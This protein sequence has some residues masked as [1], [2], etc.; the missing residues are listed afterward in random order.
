MDQLSE[1]L[2]RQIT[3]KQGEDELLVADPSHAAPNTNDHSLSLVG[4]VVI[5][6]ELSINSIRANVRRLLNPVK[7]VDIKGLGPNMVVMHFA[8]PLD[9]KHA[10]GGCPWAIDRHALLLE[11]LDPAIKPEH[12]KLTHMPI[13]IRVLQLSLSNRSESTARL[14]GNSLGTFLEIPKSTPNHY[15]PYFRLKIAV[16]VSKPLKRGVYFQG[17]EGTKQWIQIL[18]ERLPTFCFLCG[19][20]GHGEA[21]CPTRYEEGFEE[22]EGDL[23]YG[24]WMRA[25]TESQGDRGIG[26]LSIRVTPVEGSLTRDSQTVRR[27]MEVFSVN[28]H[29]RKYQS[30][31]DSA[32]DENA[33]PNIHS[34]AKSVN[35]VSSSLPG[36]RKKILVPSH[37]RKA[38]EVALTAVQMSSKRIHFQ[39]QDEVDTQE[40]AEAARQPRRD[41]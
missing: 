19:I 34:P 21:K 41:Q 8:H 7:G 39:L 9:R 25:N 30:R 23:P 18:Y 4:R 1:S 35:S 3:L 13:M 12:H 16:D 28:P 40:T 26:G 17:V 15:L 38:K 2:A 31:G 22:P 14:I 5:D 10:L 6:R 37:K 27:G 29:Q 11:P 36:S 24:S 33:D 20:L 32:R